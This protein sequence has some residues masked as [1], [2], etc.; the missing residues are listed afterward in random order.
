MII[1]IITGSLNFQSGKSYIRIHQQK[2]IPFNDLIT[3]L[4]EYEL[5]SYGLKLLGETTYVPV[6]SKLT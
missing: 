2:K 5:R 6:V 1:D 4:S 3:Q